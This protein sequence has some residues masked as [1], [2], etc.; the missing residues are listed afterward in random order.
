MNITSHHYPDNDDQ[1]DDAQGALEVDDAAEDPNAAVPEK[2]PDEPAGQTLKFII[3]DMIITTQEMV[4]LLLQ[5]TQEGLPRFTQSSPA[6]S[7]TY[8]WE[9][10]GPAF[11]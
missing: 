6:L 8:R 11:Q 3:V 9:H 7:I 4:L 10:P 1:R 5:L 2:K